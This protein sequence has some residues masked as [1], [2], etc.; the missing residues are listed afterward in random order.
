MNT[1]E[2]LISQRQQWYVLKLIP[3]LQPR[4]MLGQTGFPGIAN[5]LVKASS[6]LT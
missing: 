2:S 3:H 4:Y 6:R 1:G 5:I